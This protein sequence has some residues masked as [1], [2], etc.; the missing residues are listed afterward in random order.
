MSRT[1]SLI[2]QDQKKGHSRKGLL[3]SAGVI[4]GATMLS[5]I[6]GYIRDMILAHIFGAEMVADAFFVAFKIPNLLRRLLGEGSLSASFIPVFTE[7]LAKKEE[8][9]AW[10]L[11]SNILCLV[12]TTTILLS[13]IAIL[14]AP[15]IIFILAPGFYPDKAKF[16]LTVLLTR[17]LF[18]YIILI[19]IVAISMGILNSLRHFAVPA[20]APAALNIGIILG[21]LFLAPRLSRP[22]VGVALGVLIGG[23]LQILMQAPMLIKKGAQLILNFSIRN[24]GTKKIGMLMLPAAMGLGVSQINI[25]VDTAV[26]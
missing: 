7:Y 20:L 23:L 8:K 13:I 4:S 9:E 18:P 1:T 25:M 21:A 11:A 15:G 24:E 3:K 2:D 12:V 16:G 17:I 19:S 6:L 26:G 10:E 14:F 22:I 5:R